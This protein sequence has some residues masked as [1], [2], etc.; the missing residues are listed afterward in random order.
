M[1]KLA[2]LVSFLLMV[3]VI[4]AQDTQILKDTLSRKEIRKK[5]KEARQEEMQKQF[6]I[7]YQMLLNRSFVLEADYIRNQRSPNI[8]V[9][10]LLNFVMIDS[11]QSVIQIGSDR[12]NGLGHNGLG[13]VTA[14]GNISSYKLER[15]NKHLTCTLSFSVNSIL[16]YFD[17]FMNISASGYAS[18]TISGIHYGKLIYDGSVKP[19]EESNIYIGRSL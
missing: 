2:I 3:V 7:T 18:A 4:Q 6:E 10:Y 5:R 15:D 12:S 11:A 1:K 8:P 9:N 16:G 17:V 14:K 13:G 19:L